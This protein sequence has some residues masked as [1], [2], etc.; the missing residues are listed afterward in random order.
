MSTSTVG[1]TRGRK[2]A[3]AAAFVVGTALA[4]SGCASTSVGTTSS[5]ATSVFKQ[6]TQNDSAPITVWADSTRLPVVQK[7]QKENPGVKMNIV[8]YEDRKSVV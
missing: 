2:I 8:T 5:S 7:Y 3:S 6:T 1:R 4:L